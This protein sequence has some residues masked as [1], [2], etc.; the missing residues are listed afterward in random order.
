MKL[1]TPSLIVG[2][3]TSQYAVSSEIDDFLDR[4]FSPARMALI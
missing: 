3:S 1:F 4:I 2:C